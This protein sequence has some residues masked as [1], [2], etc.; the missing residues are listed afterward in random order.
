M[1]LR[2]ARV[3]V[4]IFWF[5]RD[6]RLTDNPLLRRAAEECEQ[7]LPVYVHAPGGGAEQGEGAASRWWLHHSLVALD[8]ELRERGSM[9]WRQRGRVA[10]VLAQ[11][12]AEIG[13]R[14]VYWNRRYEPAETAHEARLL[15]TLSR[16]GLVVT[17][18]H[19]GLLAAPEHGTKPDGS[20]Y[21]VFSA[22]WRARLRA[23]LDLAVASAP[24]RLPPLPA[25]LP[26]SER[27]AQSER[28]PRVR[29][30]DGLTVHWRPGEAGARAR[31][32]QFL[33][34]ALA[35]YVENRERPDREGTSRLSPHLHFGEIGPRQ[36]A[37]AVEAWADAGGN[38]SAA[39]AFLR[40]L[41][42]REFAHHLLYHFPETPERPLD[43]RFE[44]FPWQPDPAHL[45]A[46][47]RGETGIPLVDAGMRELWHT[48]WMHNRVRMVV[49]SFL[50]KNLLIPWQEGAAWFRDTLVDAD[51][52]NNVLG[53]Q[54]VAGSGADAA[55]YFRIFNPVTQ[56]VRF[57]PEG[58]YVT[59]WLPE[60]RGLPVHYRHRPW[61]TPTPP[62]AYPPP[63]VDLAGSRQRALAA[64]ARVRSAPR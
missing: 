30:D 39:E 62:A 24:K 58:R 14:R 55:P 56:G 28:L 13:A 40:Q 60:L 52:A 6:L 1:D 50:T 44:R 53:W 16:R 63:I 7:L 10:P 54:W 4:G 57:D 48:G 31:L 42:W 12:A 3:T 35:G 19:G 43:R 26:P 45:R 27:L 49:A 38:R 29:W 59:R 18:G 17:T 32:A 22:F 20:A 51:L 34:A 23:G 11:V 64:F 46:W 41:G 36:I 21:R 2:G 33:D 37:A 25:P 9:L 5:R 47:Q 61:Q 8:A 15:T